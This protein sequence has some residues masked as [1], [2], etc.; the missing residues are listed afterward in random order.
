MEEGLFL[1]MLVTVPLQQYVN[2][3]LTMTVVVA[4]MLVKGTMCCR[5]RIP[6]STSR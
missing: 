4:N 2:L 1:S 6:Y 3:T 5:R